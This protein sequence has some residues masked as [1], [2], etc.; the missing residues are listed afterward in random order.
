MAM[1]SERVNGQNQ[2]VLELQMTPYVL[3]V[4]VDEPGPFDPSQATYGRAKWKYPNHCFRAVHSK[5]RQRERESES[6]RAGYSARIYMVNIERERVHVH[7]TD[8]NLGRG[9]ERAIRNLQHDIGRLDLEHRGGY[10]L[11]IIHQ[12]LLQYLKLSHLFL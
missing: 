3:W 4:V 7:S 10:F 6:E 12:L 1:R 11:F 2:S 8:F 5:Q 9:H